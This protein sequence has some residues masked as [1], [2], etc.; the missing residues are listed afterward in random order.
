MTTV[1]AKPGQ[2]RGDWYVVDAS[3][4]TLGRLASQIAHRLKGSAATVGANRIAEICNSL[5]AA[6]AGE[7][8]TDSVP[9]AATTLTSPGATA[10]LSGSAGRTS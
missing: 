4:K 7:G 5:C 2:V 3:G 9:T 8:L 10:V 1:F 6:S